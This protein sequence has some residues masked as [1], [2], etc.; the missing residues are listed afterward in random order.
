[1]AQFSRLYRVYQNIVISGIII[2]VC[3]VG[4]AVGVIPAVKKNIDQAQVSRDVAAQLDMLQRKIDVL[5]SLDEDVLR[6]N[7]DT[8]LS[9]VP[10]DKSLPTVF[11]VVEGVAAQAGVSLSDMHIA[12]VGSVASQSGSQ[13]ALEKQLGTHVLPFTVTVQGPFASIQQ[14]IMLTPTVRRLLRLRTFSITFPK[15]AEVL[16]VNLQMD[17]FYEPFP[18]NL[19]SVGTVI[20]PLSEKEQSLVERISQFA[21]ISGVAAALPPP[22][23]GSGKVNPFSP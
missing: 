8:V 9:A 3:V 19:G 23:I 5:D 20:T 4:L 17:A 21:L 16:R 1:M 10:Q 15:Q 22:S 7:L 11:T 2:L 6:R 13:S 18:T 12:G 14:F